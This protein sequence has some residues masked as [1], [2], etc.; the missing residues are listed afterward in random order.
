MV[1]LVKWKQKTYDPQNLKYLLSVPFRRDL[2]TAGLLAYSDYMF[3]VCLPL[4][5]CQRLESRG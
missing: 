5:E 2:L 4:L 3:I 1:A